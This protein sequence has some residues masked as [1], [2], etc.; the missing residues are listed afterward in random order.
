MRTALLDEGEDR[1]V[2]EQGRAAVAQDHFVTVR[3]IEEF[4]DPL[5]DGADEVLHRI[6]AMRGP[7]HASTV[8]GEGGDGRWP[9][10]GGTA[11]EAAV[12]GEEFRGDG[13]GGHERR[14]CH[15]L[16]CGW[17]VIRRLKDCPRARPA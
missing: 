1:E 11:A 2:P 10:L 16:A 12:R 3:Q 9:D 15:A 5:P 8:V 4:G 14:F 13:Q 7:Q 6:L 17:L